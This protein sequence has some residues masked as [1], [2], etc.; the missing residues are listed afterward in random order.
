MQTRV[1]VAAGTAGLAATGA[2]ALGS[3]GAAPAGSAGAL[4][5][6]FGCGGTVQVAAGDNPEP[7]G[8]AVAC[9]GDILVGL[10]LD[11]RFAAARFVPNGAVDMTFGTDGIARARLRVGGPAGPAE[12]PSS[13]VLG[14]NEAIVE[15]RQ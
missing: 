2:S 5:P 6:A 9:N 1:M 14:P 3:S 13:I 4:D 15:G 11:P 7:T 8:I 12:I 10:G